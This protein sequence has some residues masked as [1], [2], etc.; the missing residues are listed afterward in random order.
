MGA[1]DSRGPPITMNKTLLLVLAGGLLAAL[2]ALLWL[3]QESGEASAPLASRATD[4]ATAGAPR[5]VEAPRDVASAPQLDLPAA[6]DADADESRTAALETQSTRSLDVVV[7][8]PAGLPADEQAQVVASWEREDGRNRGARREARGALD[9][10]GRARVDVPLDATRVELS[11]DARYLYLDS[12]LVVEAPFQRAELAP[13]LGGWLSATLVLPQALPSDVD[14]VSLAPFKATL[15]GFNMSSMGAGGHNVDQTLAERTS[16]EIGGLRPKLSYFLSID[17]Q[18]FANVRDLELRARPGEHLQR[19]YQIELGARVRGVVRGPNDA[20]VAEAMVRMEARGGWGGGAWETRSATTDAEGAFELRGISPGKQRVSA[21]REGLLSATSEELDL[22]HGHTAEVVLRMSAGGSLSGRVTFADG[23]PAAGADVV[24]MDASA[25]RVS[26]FKSLKSGD[27]GRFSFTALE[28]KSFTLRATSLVAAGTRADSEAPVAAEWSA[29]QTPVAPGADVALALEPP[30]RTSGRVLGA[31]GAPVTSFEVSFRWSD[32]GRNPQ[33]TEKFEDESGAF[34]LWLGAGEHMVNARA[35][36]F[37]PVE[38]DGVRVTAPQRGDSIVVSMR[39]LARVSGVVFGPDGKPVAGARVETQGSGGRGG[40]GVGATSNDKGAFDLTR[41]PPGVFKLVAKA[42]GFAASEPYAL[43]LAPGESRADVRLVLRV[44]GRIEGLIFDASGAPDAGRM[45]MAG[46]FGPGMGEM[47]GQSTSDDSGRFV[48]EHVVPG[49]HNLI[50][51]P[52]MNSLR[53][54]SNPA[55]LMASLKMTTVEVVDGQTTHVVL[56]APP[57]APV[58]LYGRVTRAGEPLREGLVTA[59][60]D[61]GSMLESLKFASLDADGNYVITLDKPGAYTLLV[62]R[63][64]GESSAEFH[65]N[66]PPLAEHRADLAL[67]SGAIRGRVLGDDGAPLRGVSVR[68]EQEGRSSLSM[69]DMGRAATSDESGRFEIGNLAPGAYTLRAGSAFGASASW[70]TAVR[71]GIQVE[72]ESASTYVEFQLQA[73]GLI[74]GVVLDGS[75]HPLPEASVFVRDA[76]GVLVNPFSTTRSDSAGRFRF[77]SAAPG[78]YS[79]SARAASSV[80]GDSREVRVVSGATTE[81]ELRAV[82]GTL[83]ALE[84]ETA[85]GA[86]VRAD[87]RVLD[88]AGRDHAGMMSFEAVQA[89]MRGGASSAMR[90]FGPLAP[91]KYKIVVTPSGG[92]AQ[93]KNVILTG[94]PERTVTVRVDG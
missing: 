68:H 7:Q 50:A 88:E 32:S 27:D 64:M 92:S 71:T 49:S 18:A 75:G 41:V 86:S 77:D 52:R 57:A 80:T 79:L 54:D 65:E 33:R 94:Q 53:S 82:S 63:R 29:T 16:F 24:C 60:A 91:G 25:G 87:V 83:L 56:G 8:L 93:T 61:G 13:K 67:P 1:A 90:K 70:G 66:V 35:E 55:A 28:G 3:T 20:P 78:S 14:L 36:G 4:A 37:E 11:L 34:E 59:V 85:S 89:L 2:G 45:V 73:P 58:K 19:E 48:L 42:E 31:D 62:G 5:S 51:T 46:A 81:V 6:L 84:L 72:S 17:T 26:N 44:G 15:R 10:S 22:A 76:R 38:R 9:A 47:A 21:R 40:G 74:T 43:E 30:H 23:S 69:F 12:S 39:R